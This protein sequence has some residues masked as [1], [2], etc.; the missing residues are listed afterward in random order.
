MKLLKQYLIQC[1]IQ[2]TIDDN[3]NYY[4]KIFYIYVFWFDLENNN[5]N[6][7]LYTKVDCNNK[8][9]IKTNS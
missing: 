6:Y 9:S 3:H 2:K 4:P 5:N 8:I 1:L 7:N